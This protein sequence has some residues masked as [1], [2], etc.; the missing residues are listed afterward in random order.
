MIYTLNKVDNNDIISQH[1]LDNSVSTQLS[2]HVSLN[3]DTHTL[4]YINDNTI[5]HI[6]S[7]E[8]FVIYNN[9]KIYD[10]STPDVGWYRVSIDNDYILYDCTWRNKYI[11]NIH[12]PF[13]YTLLNMS[14]NSRPKIYNNSLYYF[15]NAN[16]ICIYS[17][18]SLKINT[19]CLSFT[20]KPYMIDIIDNIVMLMDIYNIV[21][22]IDKHTG[23]LIKKF[24]R[25]AKRVYTSGIMNDINSIWIQYNNLSRKR[26]VEEYDMRKLEKAYNIYTTK[27]WRKYYKNSTFIGGERREISNNVYDIKLL[28]DDKICSPY[29]IT[30]NRFTNIIHKDYYLILDIEYESERINWCFTTQNTNRM[31]VLMCVK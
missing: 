8:T 15:N 10:K 7:P 30:C 21:Y 26:V 3:T 14:K 9:D 18:D 1:D 29:K 11:A 5:F 19:V 13:K 28:R 12:E 24:G 20:D 2:S 22:L 4:H 17:L 31:I 23:T 16:D 27:Y 6:N 25:S